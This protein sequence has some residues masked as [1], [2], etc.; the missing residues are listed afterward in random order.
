LIST[1]PATAATAPERDN[2]SRSI[3]I[4]L[5]ATVLFHVLL[6]SLAPLIKVEHVGGSGGSFFGLTGA[7]LAKGK[8]FNIELAPD[9]ITAPEP[10]KNPFKFVETNPEAPDNAPDKTE[11]FSSRNQQLAQKEPDA[12]SKL[13]APRTDGQE[14]IKNDTAIVSGNQ[15]QPQ[16]G[17]P[18]MEIAPEQ[19]ERAAQQARAE[20]I[21]LSGTEKIEGKSDDGFGAAV[22]NIK[23]PSN[24]AK[25]YLEGAKDGRD[26][27]GGLVVVNAQ[28]KQNPRE[29]PRIAQSSTARPSPIAKRILGT[30]RVGPLG[31]D[32]RWDA[33]GDYMNQYIETVQ[34][35]WY[36][37][38]EERS[39]TPPSPSY[40]VIGFTLNSDGI[41][42]STEVLE[43]STD[44]PGEL[45]AMA[46]IAGKVE[47]FKPWTEAMT[48]LFGKEQRL[49]FRFYY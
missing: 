16:A 49:V 4:G 13:Q 29:R 17:A 43:S 44:R 7:Q 25:E 19:A 26:A 14:D 24:N 30:N 1:V 45:A 5:A 31:L 42:T 32:A 40:A 33:F 46:A 39:T 6:F 18:P 34:H 36:G 48:A 38:L 8:E 37:I 22:S 12:E 21:P 47:A 2:E 41:V 35:R 3:L 23:T 27:T 11:N 28:Q 9:E 15:A 20:Q 10:V